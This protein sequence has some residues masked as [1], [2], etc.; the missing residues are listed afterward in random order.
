[1]NWEN[2]GEYFASSYRTFARF[3]QKF[4]T[5]EDNKNALIKNIY[6]SL[7]AD[8]TKSFTKNQNAEFKDNIFKIGYIGRFDTY[9]LRSYELGSDTIDGKVYNDVYIHNGYLDTL[10]SFKPAS[11]N[12]DVSRYTEQ[13]YDLYAGTIR[14]SNNVIEGG[15]LLNG[16]GIGGIYGRWAAPGAQFNGYSESEF[17][18]VG[19]SVMASAD[20]GNHELQF[21]IQYEQQKSG[22]F[23]YAPNA[24]WSLMRG[25]TN[26]H[27]LELDKNSPTLVTNDGVFQDTIYYNRKY[28]R[29]SQRTF[30]IN[31]RRK[32]GLP[33]DGTDFINIDS[34]DFDSKTINYYDKDGNMK[35]IGL[36]EDLF[37]ISLFSADELL[38][39]GNSYV[40]YRGFNYKGEKNTG[41]V[42]FEDFLQ[43]KDAAN[44]NFLRE[45]PAFE[46]IYMAG[47]I[48]DKFYF[49]DLVFNIGLRVDRFDANQLV[50]KDPFTLFNARTTKEVQ[51]LN[52]NDVIHPGNIGG[53]YVVY[54]DNVNNPT[55]IQGYRN[56]S[57]WYNA[58]G[59]EIANPSALN[60]GAGV[61]P[62]LVDPTQVKIDKSSLMDYE[63][64]VA[65]MPRISFSFPISDEAQFFAHYDIL[66]QRP[67]SNDIFDITDYYYFNTRTG[68][69]DNPNL[70]PK[71]TID[72]ELGFK[73]KLSA[74]SVMTLSAYYKEVRDD[75]QI[76]RFSGAYPRDYVS[77]N[78]IDFGTV[79]G[80]TL[81]Y[82]L[83]QTGNVTLR[84]SYTLQFADG[85][86]S[87]TQTAAALIAAGLP[88]LRTTNPLAWDRRHAINLSLDYRYGEGKSYNGP[89]INREKSGKGPIELLR[90]TGANFTLT[91]GSGTAYTRSSNITS[92]ISGGTQLLKGSY[93]GSRL[94][95]Q[96]R[97]DARFD[98]DITIHWGKNGE[99]ESTSSLNLYFQVLNIF[100]FENIM[101]VYPSTGNP[102]DDGYLAAAEW[103]REI[104]E[105]LNPETF[106]EMYRIFINNPGS[107]SSPRM[108]RFGVI[109]NF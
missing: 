98:K 3:T 20:V 50:L 26:F 108:I 76:Y 41:K 59:I 64:Q 33:V 56:G 104:N 22:F 79:K 107:Y 5:A 62:Y 51:V 109:V 30:D 65:I 71:Q 66:T 28:D 18:Q 89:R 57:T 13:Y 60:A 81:I 53:D 72:Y 24:L 31:L 85:T 73:Q 29:L 43:K 47:Y 94:P 90:N 92:G 23:T 100:N 1:M 75:I 84:A 44:E 91:G 67:S 96:F 11:F 97:V 48:Q 46:P 83:R 15:G 95:W 78:N 55:K 6:Y 61:S 27:I 52:G 9:T 4:A 25:Q 39:D 93:F 14:N 32:L 34:Y 106:R 86:G 87:N 80:F 102:D 58:D 68:V 16:D 49:K 99:K 101:G 36:G 42:T 37:D 77:Y 10:F 19:F 63:P 45:I 103:Q 70:K 12:K 8:Y 17:D 88:N 35:T 2:N 82:D 21:G 40:G 69:L 54:V 74:T 105:Q 7:Q 38:N